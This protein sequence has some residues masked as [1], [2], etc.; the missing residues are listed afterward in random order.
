MTRKESLAALGVW[1]VALAV[2]S[3][4]LFSG[5]L[6]PF[7]LGLASAYL[8]DPV[9]DR[10]QRRRLGRNTAALLITLAFFLLVV[11]VLAL[12][13]PLLVSQGVDLAERLPSFI[14]AARARFLPLIQ[15]LLDNSPLQSMMQTDSLL[16]RISERAMSIFG[17]TLNGIIQSSFAVLNLVSLI[18]VTPIVTFYL[19]RDWDRMMSYID[20]LIPRDIH[21]QALELARQVDEVLAGFFRG[22]ALVCTFL[23][24]FYACGLWLV[25][26]EYGLVIG[27]LTGFFSFVPYVGMLVGTTVGLAVAAFQFQSWPMIAVV[28]G[29]FAF[30]Q[31]LEGN[32]VT[33]RLVGERIHLHPVWVIFC[34][35]AGTLLFGFVG[36]FLAVPVTGVLGVFIRY[37]I[38]RYRE[39]GLYGA[40][41]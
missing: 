8:L 30:G 7:V 31:F 21:A 14:E 28:A 16:P 40:G 38:A 6:L 34:V 10:L 9:A 4:L 29:V 32:F 22:Q 5:V 12:V 36:T 11:S 19:L 25:G 20:G 37:A 24:I 26:L 3:L 15:N 41:R 33:P 18:F 35:L 2:M 1:T 17:T 27:I 39:S 13:V 23:A